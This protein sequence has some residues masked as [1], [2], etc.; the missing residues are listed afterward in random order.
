MKGLSALR[1]PLAV[2]MRTFFR[3]TLFSEVLRAVSGILS[4][5]RISGGILTF[6]SEGKGLCE[7]HTKE[8]FVTES[9]CSIC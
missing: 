6:E 2:R 7:P 5:F 3:R 1:V 8:G 4:G 9:F